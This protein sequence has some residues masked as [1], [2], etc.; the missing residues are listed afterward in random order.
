MIRLTIQRK[1]FLA[2]FALAATMALLLAGLTRWNLEQ[3][4][5]RYVVETE[6]GRLD[7]LVT[8]LE[9][10]YAKGG[11]W[12]FLKENIEPWDRAAE[13]LA[14]PDRPR[15]FRGPPGFE[16]RPPRPFP[17]GLPPPPGPPGMMVGGHP[18]DPLGF[19]PRLS[20]RDPSGKVLAG[21]PAA[22]GPWATRPIRFQ[23]RTVGSL[24]LRAPPVGA[25]LDLAFLAT[26]TRELWTSALAALVLSLVA[27][28]LLAR[29]LLRPIQDLTAGA[30]Q[31]TEGRFAERI[32]VRGNDELAELA[33]DFNAMAQMLARNEESRRQWI[34]D[35][36]HELRTP[37]AVLRAE[38][39]ALQDAVRTA[40]EPTLARLHRNVMQM[41]K[42]VDD[43]RQTLDQDDG[44]EDL[45]LVSLEPLPVVLDAVEEFRERF[46]SANLSLDATR[47]RGLRSGIRIKGDRDRL[48]QVFANVLENS[49]RYTDPGGRL[50]ISATAKAG[51]LHLKFDDTSPAPPEHAMA[52]LF[53][54][55]F[56]AE[57][58]R[59]RQHGGSGLGLAICKRIVEGHGGT[60]TASRSPLGGLCVL[61]DL[62]LER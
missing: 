61:I 30:R 6:I 49:L 27:A 59:S 34:S 7:W 9:T 32:P 53:E 11:S 45:E 60:I 8:N 23:G 38:I 40:D 22:D 31:I 20:L 14:R 3:G 1:V 51:R 2:T 36:S 5:T 62:P 57:P 44:Q 42:L 12:D 55:F 35:S 33:A 48:H 46:E 19:R 15:D 13:Q 26:Q 58:S 29:Q 28:W 43:L 18:P 37:I 39:E 10:A 4:F 56:R 21:H 25:A 41:S 54:R 16:D 17:D 47:M 52:R 50:E 24:A